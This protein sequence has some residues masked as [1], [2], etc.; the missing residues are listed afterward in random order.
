MAPTKTNYIKQYITRTKK[1]KTNL[2]TVIDINLTDQSKEAMATCLKEKIRK[3]VCPA[4]S[5]MGFVDSEKLVLIG[6]IHVKGN[7]WGLDQM[8]PGDIDTVA[9]TRKV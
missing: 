8:I 4:C 1:G 5:Y 9:I 2:R 6:R 3:A 7:R